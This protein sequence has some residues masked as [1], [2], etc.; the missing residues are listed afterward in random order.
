MPTF[1]A[2]DFETANYSRES[3]CQVGLIRVEK[4]IITNEISILVQPPNNSYI[5]RLTDLHGISPAHTR[6][7]PSFSRVWAQIE[8]YIANQTV[9]AHNGSF[10]FN[11][12]QKTLGSYGIMVPEYEKRCTY[13]IF[14]KKLNV[15]C[16]EHGIELNHHEALSDA[17]ACARLFL[18]SLGIA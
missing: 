7:A 9:V 16:V 12:L 11:V 6:N 3:I 8:P 10:D 13:K 4:G 18:I 1:T 5:R 2:I 17:R 14:K 15:L